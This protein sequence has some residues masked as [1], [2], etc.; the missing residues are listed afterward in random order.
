MGLLD[1]FTDYLIRRRRATVTIRKRRAVVARMLA[2]I[3]PYKATTFQLDEWIHTNWTADESINAA[4]SALRGFYRWLQA[5]GR[6]TDNPAAELETVTVRRR[7]ARI[8]AEDSILAAIAHADLPTEVMI[9]LGAEAGLRRHEIAK[10]HSDDL[11]H[12]E[13]LHVIGKGGNHRVIH[14]GEELR[15]AIHTLI[16]ARGSGFL[17]PGGAGGHLHPN[18]VYERIR[19]TVGTN[20]HALRHRAGTVVYRRTG[21]DLRLAQQFLG[22]STPEMTSRYVHVTRPDLVRASEAARLAASPLAA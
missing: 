11:E 3:N 4:V 21:N 12:G 22:H 1:E 13:W 8:A 16:R 14:L 19:R 20:T 6:R 9:R 2:D 17:F 10:V 5:S 7:P 15:D 18:T